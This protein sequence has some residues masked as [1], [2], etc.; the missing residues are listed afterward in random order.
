MRT[1]FFMV[2]S[3]ALTVSALSQNTNETPKAL[4]EVLPVRGLSIGVPSPENV[5]GFVRFIDEELAPARFNLLVLL[6]DWNYA[7]ETHPELAGKLTRADVKKIVAV[8]R[9]HGI[10]IVPQINLLG[11]QSWAKNT[12]KFLTVFPQ[13]DETPHL[14]TEEAFTG[15]EW[16]DP[17][18]FYCKSYCPLHP[19]VHQVIFDVMDE[20]TEAFETDWFHAGMDEV[21]I[22]GD[23]HCPRCSGRD[24]AELFAGEVRTIHTHL[25]QQGKRMMIW[26]DRLLDGKTT[27][28]HPSESSMNNTHRAIDMIPKDVFICDWHYGHAHQSPVYF[29]MKGF[30]V[31]ACPWNNANVAAQQLDDMLRSRER[32]TRELK[33]HFQGVIL[34]VWTGW[35]AFRDEYYNSDKNETG[36]GTLKMLIEEYK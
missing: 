17:D 21:T 7:Y 28:F 29:A 6:V 9:K 19:D 26:G 35:N 27:G 10:E 15:F 32:A 24:P 1:L 34:T 3:I 22:I 23:A 18:F 12:G 4:D 13:F 16:Y 33:P 8:C 36:A 30:D 31:A 25:A 2:V 11:H 5:D 20:L 14:K